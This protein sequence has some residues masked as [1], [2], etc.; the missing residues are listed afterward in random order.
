M[1]RGTP[2]R[3]ALDSALVALEAAGVDSPRLDAELLLAHALGVDRARLVIDR[4]LAVAGSAAREFQTLVRRRA[5]EREPVA[6]LLGR[7][8]FRH[9]DL[10]VDPRVLIP[11]PETELLVEVGLTLPA[12]SSV[13]DVGTGSGAVALALKSERPDLVVRASDISEEAVAVARANAARLALDVG[14][15]VA[16]LFAEPVDA[17]LSN[18]PYVAS[19]DELPPDVARHE[20]HGALFAG[21]D[22]LD[23]IRRLFARAGELGVPLVAVEHGMGQA[24]AVARIAEMNGFATTEHMADLAG[25]DR[26]VVARR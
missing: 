1:I 6:Y 20:P 4:H 17:V 7:K 3:D 9:I 5:I 23:V 12:S 8:G 22:G 15:A 13:I 21:G 24:E 10:D 18:P 16:D 19:G 26:V 2:V 25:I 14:F 11:R